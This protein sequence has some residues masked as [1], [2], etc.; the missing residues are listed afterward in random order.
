MPA[1]TPRRVTTSE[2]VS[3]F[4]HVSQTSVYIVKLQPPSEVLSF[5]RSRGFNYSF[6]GENVELSCTN[7]S[8]PGQ[9]LDTHGPIQDYRGYN[10]E[11]AY[12]KAYANV[13]FTFNV[14]QR[15]DVVQMFES[16][17]DFIAGQTEDER[18]Y[19]NPYAQ[20]RNNYPVTY[21]ANTYITK[22][23]KGLGNDR[24]SNLDQYKMDYTFVGSFPKSVDAMT[25][26]YD[27]S[28]VL[29]YT[30]NMNFIRYTMKRSRQF[31]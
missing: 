13:A 17:I 11:M 30:V 24:N 14:D 31:G 9:S 28:G 12:R 22:F 20:V 1:P 16:W 26:G 25:V 6:D 2:L 15:Y 27:Q 21:K 10:E 23:E 5:M 3:R 29:K 18:D 8:L 7:A 19:L 4:L